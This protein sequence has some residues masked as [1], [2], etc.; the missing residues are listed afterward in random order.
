MKT[1]VEDMR[2]NPPKNVG[3]GTM[4]FNELRMHV[5]LSFKISC[6]LRTS[7]FEEKF[8]IK[9]NHP[10]LYLHVCK[11]LKNTRG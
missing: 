2:G 11:L 6:Q 9:I 10:T 5:E 7:D 4:D 1:F 8:L 3:N